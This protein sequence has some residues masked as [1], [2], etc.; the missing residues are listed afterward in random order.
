M[1]AVESELPRVRGTRVLRL[2]QCWSMGRLGGCS[3]GLGRRGRA[4]HR[5]GCPPSCRHNTLAGIPSG[6]LPPR[7]GGLCDL[8]ESL[9]RLHR[10]R[11]TRPLAR[12]ATARGRHRSEKPGG[13]VGTVAVAPGTV[14][15]GRIGGTWK[16]GALFSHGL[17]LVHLLNIVRN[18]V[19]SAS[20][21]TTGCPRRPP[22][23]AY[24]V[25]TSLHRA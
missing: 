8:E 10:T 15:N 20:I 5:W 7:C 2:A 14:K 6:F 11:R 1:W 18:T 21:A 22:A 24:P 9:G 19:A 17:F 3:V 23:N 13:A 25:H 16:D 4:V 12:V